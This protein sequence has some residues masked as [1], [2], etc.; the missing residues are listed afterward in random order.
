MNRWNIPDWV[1]QEVVARDRRCVYC[2]VRFHRAQT[3]RRDTPSWEH[4]INDA[5]IVTR[6]NIVRCCVGCNASKG[7][8]T[9]VAWLT[10]SYC[11]ERGITQETVAPIVRAALGLAQ[12][13]P[14]SDVQLTSG[15]ARLGAA[16]S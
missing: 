14:L 13:A 12:G 6:E 3:S 8:K 16:R 7:T 11:K 5:S 9:L 4:I 15:A 1:E 2:G 10:S